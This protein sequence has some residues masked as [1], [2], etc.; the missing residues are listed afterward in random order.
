MSGSGSATLRRNESDRPI[1]ITVGGRIMHVHP[2]ALPL[3]DE[4][5]TLSVTRINPG[6]STLEVVPTTKRRRRDPLVDCRREVLDGRKRLP[7]GASG[8]ALLVE[9][10]EGN[11]ERG[12]VKM[13]DLVPVARATEDPSTHPVEVTITEVVDPSQSMPSSPSTDTRPSTRTS[14]IPRV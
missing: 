8:Q 5:I 12:G 9:A 1:P 7:V 4:T 10:C 2:L 11:R 3:E 14:A 13:E 6:Q